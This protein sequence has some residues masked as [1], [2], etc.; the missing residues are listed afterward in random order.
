M[1]TLFSPQVRLYC[2]LLAVSVMTLIVSNIIT[3]KTLSLP[4]GL[5]SS[6]GI[7]LIPL[8]YIADDLIAEV[9][10]FKVALQTTLITFSMNTVA[11]IAIMAAVALPASSQSIDQ[12]SYALI[13]G[14]TPL[15]L[16]ASAAGYIV[17][18]A[19]NAYTM[20][21]M[22]TKHG[23]RHLYAR[24]LTSTIIGKILDN[25]TFA[26]IYFAAKLDPK[27]L[28]ILVAVEVA[29]SIV[30]ESILYPL[31][32]RPLINWGKRTVIDD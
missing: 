10:G 17:G 18:S 30:Y 23:Q 25:T 16:L 29:L 11:M 19:S 7:L 9:Y 1:K 13:L 31:A 4:L 27:T 26:L 2:T 6:A 20:H 32:T 15:L 22:R 3:S 14:Q 5:T 21:Y 28:L 24:C 8:A 12:E